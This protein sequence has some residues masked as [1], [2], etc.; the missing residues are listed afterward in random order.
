MAIPTA[1]ASAPSMVIPESFT[2]APAATTPTAIPSGRLC[3][4]TASTSMTVF[5]MSASASPCFFPSGRRRGTSRSRARRKPTPIKK[6]AAAGNQAI[7]PCCCSS[8]MAGISKDHTEAAIMTPEAKPSK[9]FSSFRF[10]FPFK[11]NTMAAPKAVPKKGI[12]NTI[13]FSISAPATQICVPAV[14]DAALFFRF[15]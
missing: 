3:S 5:C 14:R 6:P 2:M 8:S 7:P 4:P 12:D 11:K 1:R 10:I 9:I 13:I 15:E